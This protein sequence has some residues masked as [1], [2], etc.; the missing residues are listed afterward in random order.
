MAYLV[1]L[2]IVG[3]VLGYGIRAVWHHHTTRGFPFQK[4]MI[5]KSETLA[6]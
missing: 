2:L 6:A 3:F 1:A 5:L 4:N